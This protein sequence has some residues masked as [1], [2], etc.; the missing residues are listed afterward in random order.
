MARYRLSVTSL[1][2]LPK[3]VLLALSAQDATITAKV[4]EKPFAPHP[5]TTG[6]C[7]A[8]GGKARRDSSRLCSRMSAIASRKFA[9]HSSCVLPCP[10]APGNSAQYDTNQGPSCSTIAVNSLR[11][12]TFYAERPVYKSP[13][14]T[15][16]PAFGRNTRDG[17][18]LLRVQA[19]RWQSAKGDNSLMWT[20]SS[21][22]TI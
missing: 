15:I 12:T 13:R 3:S 8:S 20:P 9:R 17:F 10:F 18:F 21:V 11:M 22:P 14:R 4:P 19:R 7:L 16:L 2:I 6:S 5:T 1:W